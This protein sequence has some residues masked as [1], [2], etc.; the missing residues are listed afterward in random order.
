[1]FP[2]LHVVP[3]A[4][5]PFVSQHPPPLHMLPAQQAN[6]DAPHA[7]HPPVAQTLPEAEHAAPLL[8]HW[9]VPGSQHPFALHVE[10]VQHA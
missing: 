9:L 6:P 3:D 7:W 8:T 2:L 5:Q 1:V 4:M 10:P